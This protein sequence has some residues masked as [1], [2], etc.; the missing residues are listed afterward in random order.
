MALNRVRCPFSGVG[1]LP[2]VATFHVG[3]GVTD[4]SP[5]RAFWLAIAGVFPNSLI[6]GTPNSGDTINEATGQIT[7]AWTGPIQSS[8]VGTGGAG[9]YSP[10]IGPMVRWITPQVV[11]GRRP[12]GKTFLIPS[13]SSIQSTAGT[14][15]SA[16]ITTIANAAVA[17]VV[18]LA[19]EL[20]TW[21]RPNAKGPGVACTI[22]GA[23]VSGKQMVLRSRRD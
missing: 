14:F 4:M 16:I 8:V 3:S 7:G 11:D 18:A 22:T 6:I 21:H 19:G 15:T 10:T 20:K 1:G 5:I 12:I 13:S 23:S 9:A 17:L 2:G